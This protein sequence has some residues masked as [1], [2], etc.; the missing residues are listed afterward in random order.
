MTFDFT[1]RTKQDL[2]DA[3]QR[4]GFVP[5]FSGAVPGF[6]VEEHAVRDVWYTSDSGDWLVWDWKGPVIRECGCAYG[7][8]LEKKAVFI[9]EEWFP[10]FANYRRDGYDFDA[11]WDDGLA[12]H[13][14]KYLY[15]L[16]ERNAPVLSTTLK[17]LGGY[18]KDGRKGF[19]TVITRLQ[20]Q[21]YVLIEDFVYEQDKKGNEFGWGIARYSTPERCFGE[22]FRKTVYERTPEES[23]ARLF[24]H[25]KALLPWAGDSEIR[26]ILK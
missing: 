11:R 10:D 26:K 6:S 3:V 15:D 18:G 4:F 22:G 21:G 25:L 5:L 14:D 12:R 23:Y 19:D 7:K 16:L 9:S 8:F 2:I 1:V 20:A 24:A 17:A 13:D